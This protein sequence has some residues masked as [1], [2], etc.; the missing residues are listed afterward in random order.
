MS[1]YLQQSGL[2]SYTMIQHRVQHSHAYMYI[3][4]QLYQIPKSYREH[5]IVKLTLDSACS[6]TV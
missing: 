3:M 1:L 4:I 5:V 6:T 2:Y